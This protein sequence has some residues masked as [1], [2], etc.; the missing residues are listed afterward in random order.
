MQYG[1]WL[2]TLRAE[3]ATEG[4]DHY[5]MACYADRLTSYVRDHLHA[6]VDGL[7]AADYGIPETSL[8]PDDE[9][10]EHWETTRS[11]YIQQLREA[12]GHIGAALTAVGCTDKQLEL[13][14]TKPD[15]SEKESDLPKSPPRICV[16]CKK[17]VTDL[18]VEPGL[19]HAED[20]LCSTE[21][22][23]RHEGVETVQFKTLDKRWKVSHAEGK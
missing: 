22:E 19:L 9:L 6:A 2:T 11:E 16:E 1:T 23:D 8:T 21:C 13:A 12:L 20:F 18:M 15:E 10:R 14:G 3:E 7:T 5:E 4:V 17:E